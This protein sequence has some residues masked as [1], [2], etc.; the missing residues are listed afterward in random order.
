MTLNRCVWQ[1]VFLGLLLG[2]LASAC[3]TQP[4]LAPHLSALP[5]PK[6]PDNYKPAETTLLEMPGENCCAQWTHEKS[7]IVFLS[8]KRPHHSQFQVYV[9]DLNKK[10]DRRISFH[11]GDDQGPQVDSRSGE[12][13]YASTTDFLKESPRFLQKALG[14]PAEPLPE[15]GRRPLWSLEGFD[16]YVARRD[17]TGIRRLTTQPGFDGEPRLHP[18][19]N[20]LIFTSV[21]GNQSRLIRMDTDGKKSRILTRVQNSESE[22]SFSPSGKE[23]AWVRYAPDHQTSQIWTAN[24]DG[25]K[26]RAVTSG[27]GLRW[28]PI[29]SPNGQHIIFSSNQDDPDNFELY[30][31]QKDG[32]CVQRLTYA[33]GQDVLPA[34]GAT[35]QPLLFSSDR[36][37]AFQ[38]HSMP[39]QPPTC[40]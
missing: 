27:E 14:Q 10:K 35:D 15:I 29:W 26:A 8:R 23:L 19:G 13:Y 30:M 11:D 18:K 6:P 3:Q 25:G 9:Y 34:W 36:T 39:V 7:Q 16:L 4:K 17:G 28:S 1:R 24:L 33:L 12:F 32:G 2:G 21:S 20:F 31:M 37:G 5:Q 22:A 38:I 40:P